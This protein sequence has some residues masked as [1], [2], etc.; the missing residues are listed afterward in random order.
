[1]ACVYKVWAWIKAFIPSLSLE[2]SGCQAA[3][4]T[5][6]SRSPLQLIY[7]YTLYWSLSPRWDRGYTAANFPRTLH[8]ASH[9][10][11]LPCWSAASSESA[12]GCWFL[13]SFYTCFISRNVLWQISV[14]F[15]GLHFPVLLCGSYL[16]PCSFWV[17]CDC[18]PPKDRLLLIVPVLKYTTWEIEISIEVWTV[19]PGPLFNNEFLVLL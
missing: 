6:I 19:V 2:L 1:M 15:R 18:S 3:F 4:S 11:S 17:S 13:T 14:L 16:V 9:D 8:T 5:W 12:I 10:A 7:S